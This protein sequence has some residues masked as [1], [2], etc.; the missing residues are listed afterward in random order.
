M[1]LTEKQMIEEYYKKT[2]KVVNPNMIKKIYEKEL[3]PLKRQQKKMIPLYKNNQDKV[4][5]RETL[6]LKL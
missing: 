6:E 3:N 5:N 4:Y 2:G 1:P